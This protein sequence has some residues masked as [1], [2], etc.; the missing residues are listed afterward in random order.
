MIAWTSEG[1]NGA[2]KANEEWELTSKFGYDE[3]LG[4][5]TNAL[6]KYLVDDCIL[7]HLKTMTPEEANVQDKVTEGTYPNGLVQ[8]G[9]IWYAHHGSL[10][11]QWEAK[12]EPP[13]F[14]G[15]NRPLPK[16]W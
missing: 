5:D 6:A 16:G 7:E 15:P 8:P 3:V 12:V 14:G 2:K 1:A 13:H 9:M 11:L 4:D 10:V